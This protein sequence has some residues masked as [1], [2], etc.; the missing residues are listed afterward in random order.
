MPVAYPDRMPKSQ[1]NQYGQTLLSSGL[2]APDFGFGAGLIKL[3]VNSGG[4]AY[5]QMNGQV[6]TTNDYPL[7]SGDLLTDWYNIG[8]PVNGLSIVSTSTAL[9]IR[10]G[11]WG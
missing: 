1:A 10:V 8:V 3:V 2:V 7:T 4:P 6:A 11:A 9:S 5:I